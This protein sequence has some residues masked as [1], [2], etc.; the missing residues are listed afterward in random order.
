MMLILAV[1]P[2]LTIEFAVNRYCGT[3]REYLKRFALVFLI[4][5]LI[6]TV[7]AMFGSD[8]LTRGLGA[9]TGTD[10]VLFVLLSNFIT[11]ALFEEALK[12]TVLRW[13]VKKGDPF[14]DPMY[15]AAL[16]VTV[17][18]G[19][20]FY[21]QM[22]FTLGENMITVIMRAFLSV[23]GHM[24]HAIIMGYFLYLSAACTSR[25]DIAGRKRNLRIA[26]LLPTLTH[27]CYDFIVGM[28]QLTDSMLYE[29][30]LFIYTIALVVYAIKLLK[31]MKRLPEA[32]GAGGRPD[33]VPEAAVSAEDRTGR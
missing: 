8:A 24:A 33:D 18:M 28:L 32:D 23:P 12:Y 22:V 5:G 2:P 16:S 26:L 27:G 7:A 15:S 31:R 17:S 9:L 21:E 25:N 20:A 3:K 6:I 19:F 4:G 29:A 13:R 1:I 14:G 30:L 11:I 10:N